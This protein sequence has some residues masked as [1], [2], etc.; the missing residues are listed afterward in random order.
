MNGSL[1]WQGL[2]AKRLEEK[3][4]MI[5]EMKMS[6]SLDKLCLNLPSEFSTYFDYCRNLEFTEE[7]NYDYLSALFTNLM[8]QM[9]L[10][11]NNVEFDWIEKVSESPRLIR[12]LIDDKHRNSFIL[13]PINKSGFGFVKLGSCDNMNSSVMLSNLH[14][15]LNDSEIGRKM[16]PNVS[17]IL[18]RKPSDNSCG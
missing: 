2:K 6:T 16:S 5:K 8:R 11:P 10:D 17:G 3:F 1:P 12:S 18:R 9:D 13:N 4:Q 14:K 15:N 7:P